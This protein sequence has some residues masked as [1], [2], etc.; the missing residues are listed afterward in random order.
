MTAIK[1]YNWHKAIH[2]LPDLVLATCYVNLVSEFV[3][4]ICMA[5]YYY[6]AFQYFTTKNGVSLEFWYL[7]LLRVKGQVL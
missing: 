7:A 6:S 5:Q 2:E 1:V 4:E 3:G